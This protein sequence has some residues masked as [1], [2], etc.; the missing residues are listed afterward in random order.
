V[1]LQTTIEETQ[2]RGVN[3][4]ESPDAY[5]EAEILLEGVIDGLE[6]TQP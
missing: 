2:A 3:I 5:E 4:L 1:I 6:V